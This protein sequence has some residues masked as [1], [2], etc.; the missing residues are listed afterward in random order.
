MMMQQTRS[1]LGSCL[2]ILGSAIL[3]SSRK[4]VS[5]PI[6]QR[7][8]RMTL[9]MTVLLGESTLNRAATPVLKV[10]NYMPS[11]SRHTYQTQIGDFGLAM[12]LTDIRVNSNNWK[13][14]RG[15]RGTPGH[16]TPVRYPFTPM[17]ISNFIP[18]IIHRA[19]GLHKQTVSAV[20]T[21]N[22]TSGKQASSCG[23]LSSST[24]NLHILPP[25]N[26]GRE[27]TFR[28]GYHPLGKHTV[29]TSETLLIVTR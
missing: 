14:N 9:K 29:K 21:P 5:I 13:E 10:I 19:L 11:K 28:A 20:I 25:Q 1:F 16:Y 6:T 18:G 8:F 23:N 17:Y 24:P 7:R 26:T 22:E 4:I 2:V 15:R 27:T 12:E 3:I